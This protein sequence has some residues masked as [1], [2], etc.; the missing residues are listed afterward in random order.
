VPVTI[1]LKT[2]SHAVQRFDVQRSTFDIFSQPF[3]IR[4]FCILRAN[5]LTFQRST[6]DVFS[7][8]VQRLTSIPG[9]R[10]NPMSPLVFDRNYRYGDLTRL[11]KARAEL[12]LK[13]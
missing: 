9:G 11:P 3:N 4:R 10:I 13:P 5:V 7:R 2:Y 1:T 6:F 12:E 8:D